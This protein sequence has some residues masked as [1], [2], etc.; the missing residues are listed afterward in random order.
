[1]KPSDVARLV[2]LGLI[3]GSSYLFIKVA[4]EDVRTL[5]LVA[6]RLLLGAAVLLTL[7]RVKDLR[8]PEGRDAYRA[9]AVMALLANVLPFALITWGEERITSSMTGVLNSTTP[10]FTAA[11][12]VF[13]LREERFTA[14]RL[15]GALLGFAGVGVILGFGDG[16][17]E[18]AGQVAVVVA[19]LSYAIAFVWA[20]VKITSRGLPPLV[21]AAATVGL[22]ALVMLPIALVDALAAGGPEFG[23]APWASLVALGVLGTGLAYVLYYRLIGDI[24]PT[25][26]SFVTYLIPIFAVALGWIVLDEGVGWDT[27]VGALLVVAGIAIAEQAA[28]SARAKAAATESAPAATRR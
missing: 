6:L 20:R 28:R 24:G 13:A 4:L 12:V 14:G 22:S 25:S 27:L 1:M 19:A 5:Q 26:T 10:L 7:V 15:A 2:A 3:W 17:N 18:L 21:V 9:L 8:L 16:D 11:I 23:L